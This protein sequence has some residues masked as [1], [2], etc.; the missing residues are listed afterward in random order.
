MTHNAIV[1]ATFGS[2]RC[3]ELRCRGAVVK[4]AEQGAQI[5]S[6]QPAHQREVVWMSELAA[7]QGGQP[8]RG[9]IPVCWPW[10]GV[11]DQNPEAV[12]NSF[13]PQAEPPA[14]GLVRH[15]D[16]T[17]LDTHSEADR[18]RIRLGLR[19]RGAPLKFPLHAELAIELSDRLSVQL[20][21]HNPGTEPVWLSAALHT[22]FSVSHIGNIV[23]EGLE[24]HAFFDAL[25]GW[26][27]KSEAGPVRIEAETDRVYTGLS[28]SVR[29]VDAGWHRRIVL[30][31][32]QSQSAVL[33]NPWVAKAA[34]L[35]E[36]AADAWQRMVCIET[37]RVMADC[38]VVPPGESASFGVTLAALPDSALGEIDHD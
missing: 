37:A 26:S 6:Y 1:P 21:S 3:W 35:S 15:Q 12:R 24:G 34:R 11:F 14:H 32:H 28:Q 19:V 22:Y 31:A 9:G 30:T 4:V 36:F 33:W 29:I 8:Q 38:L 27:R 25:D 16:W 13:L 23:I 18:V 5:L 17:L 2:L 10:F 7:G 20:T